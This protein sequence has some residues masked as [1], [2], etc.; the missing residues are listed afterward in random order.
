MNERIQEIIE[1]CGF[2]A[3][4]YASREINL[5]EIEFLCETVVKECC[6]QLWTE[7]CHT[8]DLAYLEYTRNTDKIKRYFGVY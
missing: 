5:K 8:S 1:D 3:S 6:K 2:Y 7:E 4:V